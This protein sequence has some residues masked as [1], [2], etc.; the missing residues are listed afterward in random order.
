MEISKNDLR[1]AIDPM[2]FQIKIVN[3][4]FTGS[5]VNF[6]HNTLHFF[7]YRFCKIITTRMNFLK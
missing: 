1:K 4:S 2:S 7:K 6:L 3:K 5:I